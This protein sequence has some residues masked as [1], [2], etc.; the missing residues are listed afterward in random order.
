M[1]LILLKAK[2]RWRINLWNSSRGKNDTKSDTVLALEQLAS[3]KAASVK[4]KELNYK[5]APPAQA[6]I[7]LPVEKAA[8]GAGGLLS[9]R[10]NKINDAVA[11]GVNADNNSERIAWGEYTPTSLNCIET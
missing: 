3:K 5:A 1:D 2:W 9:P 8:G 7:D 6:K 4:L 11:T 10:Q